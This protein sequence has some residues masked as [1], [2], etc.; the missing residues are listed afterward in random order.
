M[1]YWVQ[2]LVEDHTIEFHNV[3][4]Q[5]SLSHGV[6][7]SK[8]ALLLLP[9]DIVEADPLKSQNNSFLLKCYGVGLFVC[10]S[11]RWERVRR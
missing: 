7:L 3:F 11:V 1:D 10:L 2:Y 4:A 5:L 6:M 9:V 8:E